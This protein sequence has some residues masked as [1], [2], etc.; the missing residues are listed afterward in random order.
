MG[1]DT[2]ANWASTA[3]SD[4]DLVGKEINDTDEKIEYY[5]SCMSTIDQIIFLRKYD[6]YICHNGIDTDGHIK[7]IEELSNL[8]NSVSLLKPMVETFIVKQKISQG[9]RKKM[10]RERRRR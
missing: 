2:I 1:N 8:G 9:Q 4:I 6:M 5:D 7:F 10:Y 3:L